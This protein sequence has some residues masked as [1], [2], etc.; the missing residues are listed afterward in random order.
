MRLLRRTVDSV[1]ERNHISAPDRELDAAERLRLLMAHGD[2]PLAYAAATEPYLKSFGDQ[3]GF[4]A[5]GQKMGYTFAMGDP[6][7][8]AEDRTDLLR[9]FVATFRRPSFAGISQE[10]ADILA[11]QGYR[12]TQF[13]LDS[14]LD[15]PRHS[16][17][18][19][20]G[21]SIRYATSWMKQN[22]VTVEE[23]SIDDFPVET[24]ERMSEQWRRTRVN[25]KREIRFLNR[26][27]VPQP[28]EGVRRFF[29]I[30]AAGEPIALVSFDPLYRNGKAVGYLASS[31]RRYPETSSYVDLGI[32]RHAIDRFR[33]EGRET[34]WLGLLPMA[35]TKA[36]PGLDDPLLRAIFAWA[37]RSKWVN[38][39]IFGL[40]GIAAYKDRYRGRDIPVYVATP[41]RSSLV[42]LI[43]LLRLIKLI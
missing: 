34:F 4:V 5:Y 20:D 42:T 16:F 39:R 29:A 32:M 2:F 9:E 19:K 31:K 26:A 35:R 17:A 22:A 24:I 41:G 1:L 14:M 11:D 30:D 6:V 25:S 43:A 38:T 33:E 10:V 15:L 27:F 36:L 21:K 28:E 37:Y 3:R 7:V 23:R 8:G 12:I 13:G 18:G 40:Q